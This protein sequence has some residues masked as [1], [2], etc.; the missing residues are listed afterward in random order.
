[1][2]KRIKLDRKIKFTNKKH[3]L[4]GFVSI[5]IGAAALILLIISFI[6]AFKAKGSAGEVVGIYGGLAL[7]IGLFGFLI[8]MFSL[9]NKEVFYTF[10]WIGIILNLIVWLVMICI[11]LIGV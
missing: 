4:M 10:S 6:I 7:I 11:F 9:R 3:S 2:G 8:G 5:I 1:M